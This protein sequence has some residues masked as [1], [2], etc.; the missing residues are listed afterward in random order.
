MKYQPVIGLEVHVQLLTDTK[1]F[2]GCSTKFGAEPNSQTCPVCLGM[3]GALPVLNKKVV[4]YAIT[5][6][7]S[8]NCSIT[9][10]SIFAR[11][12]YFYPDLP[13]GYQISQ[14]EEPI[15]QHGWLDISVDG[16]ESKRIGITRIHMEEDAGKLV[17]G[18]SELDDGSGV[19]LNRA[20][21]PLLE[22][23]S[24]PDLRSSDEAVSYLKQL[25]QIVTW[26]GICDGNMEEGSFRCDANVSVMPVG[27]GTFGT[28]AEI[29]NVNS[30][31]FVKQAIEYEIQRQIDLIE[32]GGT[33]VQ[34]TRLFD[35]NSGRTRSM[36]SK[37]EAHD[38][39]YFPDPDLVPIIIGDEWVE[40]SR[41]ELPELPEQRQQRF[42][43]RL[44]LPLYDA[45]VLTANRA[46]ADY[47][48]AGVAAYGSAKAVGNWIM[49]EITRSLNDSGTPI[50]ACPVSPVQ[51][52]ELLKL[53]DNG[54]ISG[55]IAKTVFDEMWRSGKAP[56]TVVE[57]QGLVQVSDSSAIESIIDEIMAAN[58]GQVDEYRGGKDK[59]F[60]F[61]V[62]QVMKASKGKANPS[63]VNELLLNKLKG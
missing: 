39:R 17:H 7:L 9:P 10:R 32:D 36:R 4:E 47:F 13:K 49:G 51:L 31:K 19:D 18:D 11:K 33:V 25:H 22:V 8:T 5:A 48:E 56:Q 24:E 59:V 40:R 21:T 50:E 2:C 58:A 34:E 15:C 54:T 57:E 55:K 3:P 37:E 16:G 53:I 44:G 27:S 62:G 1:I 61:F 30:F 26:L 43:S 6:G 35:P 42:I 12:N 23:V 38:Y 41:R 63:V 52:A 20:C 60:G 29:K 14:F 46:L 28:R 45:E